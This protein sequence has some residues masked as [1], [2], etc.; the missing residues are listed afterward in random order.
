LPIGGAKPEIIFVGGLS[1]YP[2]ASAVKRFLA[3]SWPIVRSANPDVSFTVV[4]RNPP[5]WLQDY[6]KRDSRVRPTGFVDDIRP[7]V[8]NAT[9]FIC[10]IFDGGGTKLKMLDAMS[11]AKPIV[12]HPIACEGLDA[13]HG[14]HL[15]VAETPQDFASS[16]L[17]LLD[18][19]EKRAALGT[20][21]RLH[22]ERNF[23]FAAIGEALADS[24]AS[25]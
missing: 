3:A 24:Y 15:L 23:S 22:V 10:P 8:E 17:S 2:N 7:L 25:L 12:A 6:A 19:A 4:G 1:W 11:M 13:Q 18:D 9:I 20:A 21:A 5:Q 16:I 14:L